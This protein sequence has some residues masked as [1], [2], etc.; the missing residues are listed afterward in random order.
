MSNRIHIRIYTDR[1]GGGA[2]QGRTDTRD[3]GDFCFGLTV[4][5][6]DTLVERIP[7]LLCG[8]AYAGKDHRTGLRT[9][10]QYAVQLATGNDIKPSPCFGQ[11]CQDRNI[12]VRFNGEA[13]LVWN[14]P[15]SRLV[16]QEPAQDGV[17]RVHIA[18]SAVFLRDRH[19]VHAFARKDVIAVCELT[20][21]EHC[22]KAKAPAWRSLFGHRSKPLRPETGRCLRRWRS[23]RT[24]EISGDSQPAVSQG[25]RVHTRLR[26]TV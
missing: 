2:P 1:D 14:A 10:G 6:V 3:L 24:G 25:V 12:R 4:E 20:L 18:G 9:S 23:Q 11:R 15:Q 22:G 21:S 13:D 5:A 8:L 17:F 7:D 26:Q 16:L 19:K